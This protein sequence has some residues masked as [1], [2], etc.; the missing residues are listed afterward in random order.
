MKNRDVRILWNVE[1]DR[2]DKCACVKDDTRSVITGLVVERFTASHDPQYLYNKYGYDIGN[3]LSHWDTKDY[4]LYLAAM[5]ILVTY[6]PKNFD[7]MVHII[8]ELGKIDEFKLDAHYL[9]EKMVGLD[10]ANE[11]VKFTESQIS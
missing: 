8:A 1:E 5:D 11:L 4:P 7:T 10:K 6:R 2:K 3:S 9:L